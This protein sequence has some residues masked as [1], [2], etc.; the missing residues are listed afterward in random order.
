MY[1]FYLHYNYLIY[2]IV[3][4]VEVVERIFLPTEMPFYFHPVFTIRTKKSGKRSTTP[5][6][7]WSEPGI[8]RL[9]GLI[10]IYIDIYAII[11]LY[12]LIIKA[13]GLLNIACFL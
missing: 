6:A 7:D 3:E 1:L 10:G 8:Y 5:T 13:H 2:N 9:I 4:S 12:H 11:F